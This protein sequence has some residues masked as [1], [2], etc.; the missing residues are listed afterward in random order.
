MEGKT[1]HSSVLLVLDTSINRQGSHRLSTG[2]LRGSGLVSANR[3]NRNTISI[4]I[5]SNSMNRNTISIS[6]WWWYLGGCEVFGRGGCLCTTYKKTKIW[7]FFWLRTAVC[8]ESESFGLNVR[9]RGDPRDLPRKWACARS[10]SPSAMA[11]ASLQGGAISRISWVPGC[12]E[13]YF[14]INI[15]KY[16]GATSGILLRIMLI[17]LYLFINKIIEYLGAPC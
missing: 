7:S 12:P 9:F 5:S 3:T 6:W 16:L 4:S 2:T 11:C 14:V 17:T 10:S 1:T 13:L 15:I 8:P